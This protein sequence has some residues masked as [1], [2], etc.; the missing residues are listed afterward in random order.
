MN[1]YKIEGMYRINTTR[2]RKSLVRRTKE[3]GT[4]VPKRWPAG[5]R[6]YPY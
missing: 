4:S 1:I 3:C 5:G 6:K 2:L